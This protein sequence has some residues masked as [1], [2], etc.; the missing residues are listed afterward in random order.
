MRSIHIIPIL[1]S[2]LFLC[3]SAQE[4]AIKPII[5][6]TSEVVDDYSI[7]GEFL[8]PSSSKFASTLPKDFYI[9]KL[10]DAKVSKP[11]APV[12]QVQDARPNLVI[13]EN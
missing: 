8:Y 5:I 10:K 9:N 2:A 11:D 1:L 4:I 7:V 13:F 3:L 12:N 6:V